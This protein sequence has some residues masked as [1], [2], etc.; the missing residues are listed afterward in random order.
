MVVADA[1]LFG[2]GRGQE[3]VLLEP[4]TIDQAMFIAE[5]AVASRMYAVQSPEAALMILMTGRD[6][7][8][9]SQTFRGIYV[10]SGKTRRAVMCSSPRFVALDS[11]QLARAGEH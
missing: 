11:A 8:S 2:G 4:Q 7:A 1:R 6:P 9:A 3:L 10:V 5:K